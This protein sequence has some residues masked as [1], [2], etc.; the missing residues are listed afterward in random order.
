M[1]AVVTGVVVER[2][3]S[4]N[5][6]LNPVQIA[7]SLALLTGI[8]CIALSFLRAGFVDNIISGYLLVGS[9]YFEYDSA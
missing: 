9:F 1:T 4:L 3:L 6:S 2:E 8:F 5:S 7:N